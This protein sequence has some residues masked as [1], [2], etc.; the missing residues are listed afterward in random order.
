MCDT[1]S[2]LW[3]ILKMHLS[4]PAIKATI[5]D[6]CRKAFDVVKKMA[7]RDDTKAYAS[8]TLRFFKR[9]LMVFGGAWGIFATVLTFRYFGQGLSLLIEGW[10]GTMTI[11]FEVAWILMATKIAVFTFA[12]LFI[13]A[14]IG[15]V[16]DLI[17]VRHRLKAS[18]D[19]KDLKELVTETI[20]YEFRGEIR[21]ELTD[22]NERLSTLVGRQKGE[23]KGRQTKAD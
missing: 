22:I 16:Y 20:F 3:Q 23:K 8:F 17:G 2:C 21:G 7:K 1:F 12:A 11:E 15:T 9:I 10:S 13:A 18:A 4:A 5:C 14:I 19:V 6:F